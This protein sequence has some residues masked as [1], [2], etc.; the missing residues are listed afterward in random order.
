MVCVFSSHDF[1]LGF[2]SDNPASRLY[3]AVA[4]G[5]QQTVEIKAYSL[6]AKLNS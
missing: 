6:S 4:C 1:P 2:F 5:D 3:L